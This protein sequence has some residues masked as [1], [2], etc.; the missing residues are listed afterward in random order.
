MLTAVERALAVLALAAGGYICVTTLAMV[1]QC[2]TA[3]PHWDQWDNL[4][5]GFDELYWGVIPLDVPHWFFIQHNEHRIA[6]PRLIF[7]IDRFLVAS[8]NKVNFFCL[9]AI[10]LSLAGLVIY[11]AIRA[12]GQRIAEKIW[13][14]G[15]VLALLFSAMQWENFLWG[16]QVQF[17]G[18]TLAAVA[19]FAT[20]ASGRPSVVRLIWVIV[21]Q[22]IAVYTMSSGVLIPILTMPLALWVTWPRR[23]VVVLG[24]AGAALLAGY[25]WGYHVPEHNDDPMRAIGHI[26][27]VLF[28]VLSEMGAPF[29]ILVQEAQI[30]DP[31]RWSQVCGAV[32]VL[33]SGGF[34]IDMLRRRERGGPFPTLIAAILFALGM[35]SLTALG[36]V[37]FGLPLSSRYSSLILLFWACLIIIA[38]LRLR[39]HGIWLGILV[40]VAVLPLLLCL[41]YYQPA[42][43]AIGRAWTLPRLEATTALLASVDDPKALQHSYPIAAIPWRRAPLLR[44]RHLS[45][46]AEEWT[47]WLGTPLAEHARPADPARCRG[48]IDQVSAVGD[49]SGAWRAGGWAWDVERRAVPARIV[50][51]D[52]SGRVVGY[53]LTGPLK[54]GSGDGG[55]WR[56]H[57]TAAQPGSVV[58]FALLDGGRSACRL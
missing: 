17:L 25:L 12:S 16:F 44:E 2:W 5:L 24:L 45:I 34:A 15:I 37:K 19:T 42:F 38:M 51:A 1:A 9:G 53:G 3:L 46:F 48:G 43:R 50:F 28:Y 39:R 56:G 21:L 32:G 40:M 35:A 20:V 6:V 18:V 33:L 13:I 47:D 14:A 26:R 57:F 31:Q 29:G 55:G 54:S 7:T 30:G 4:I 22:S 36:R 58:A 8:T 27:D 41:V 23:Y 10:Q 49:S 11:I 52:S